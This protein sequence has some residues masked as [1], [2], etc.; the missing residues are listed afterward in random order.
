MDPTV[1]QLSLCLVCGVRGTSDA[2]LNV[3]LF[4]P[5]GLLL[6]A[7]RWRPP[8]S[9]LVGFG[10]ACS[11]ELAQHFIPGRY[12]NLG[13]VVWNTTG[14]WAGAV[15]A[16]RGT[17]WLVPA[18]SWRRRLAGLAALAPPVAT[19]AFGWLMEPSWPTARYWGQWT[20]DLGHLEQYDGSV[21]RARLGSIPLPPGRFPSD[22]DP[23]GILTGDWTLDVAAV[24]GNPPSSLAPIVSIYDADERE[25]L[26]LGA[27]GEDM[28]YRE[29]SRA[30]VLRLDQP[31]LRFPGVLARAGPGDTVHLAVRRSGS[32]RCLS[33][34]ERRSCPSYTPGRA[35]SL[36]LYPDTAPE[37]GRRAMDAFW[38]WLILLPVGFWSGRVRDLLSGGVL[39]ALGVGLAV[40]LTRL[41]APPWTE[42][43]A[44]LGGLLVGYASRRVLRSTRLRAGARDPAPA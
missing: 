21:V 23:R 18:A 33:F 24:K 22:Q 3:L 35:W 9:A 10:L 30:R 6:G 16:A 4:V 25:V 40:G 11:I 12:S 38:M 7:N 31:D 5:L 39:T 13:D 26:L 19:L 36:L 2:V 1:P 29:P 20:P 17:H 44:A 37:G 15:L 34:D 27:T 8:R 42:M 41:A 14:A 28:V 32:E 43:L